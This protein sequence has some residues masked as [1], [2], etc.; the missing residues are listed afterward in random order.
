MILLGE[1]SS[2]MAL[3]VSVW[4]VVASAGAARLD[5]DDLAE[6]GRRALTATFALLLVAAAGLVT[7]LVTHDFTRTYVATHSG[8]NMPMVYAVAAFWSGLGG[9]MLLLAIALS[10]LTCVA[11]RTSGPSSRDARASGRVAFATL[12]IAMAIA[13]AC[14]AAK[15][16]A[17]SDF[18]V[19]EGQGLAPALQTMGFVFVPPL[20]ALALAAVVVLAASSWG[21]VIRSEIDRWARLAATLL[22]LALIARAYWTYTTLEGVR[23]WRW[24]VGEGALLGLW[25]L[26]EGLLHRASPNTGTVEMPATLLRLVFLGAVIGIVFGGPMSLH[27]ATTLDVIPRVLLAAGLLATAVVAWTRSPRSLRHVSSGANLG[28]DAGARHV[29][30][31]AIG[32][33]TACVLAALIAT[34]TIVPFVEAWM[35]GAA[36]M[37]TV[38]SDTVMVIASPLF[39]GAF[40]AAP[41]ASGAVSERRR[42]GVLSKALLVAGVVTLALVLSGLTSSFALVVSALGALALALIARD[43]VVT[44]R[45][46]ARALVHAGIVCVVVGLSLV[47]LTTTRDAT[48]KPGESV[49]MRDPMG[50]AWKFTGQGVSLYDVVN[51]RVVAVTVEATREGVARGIVKT[52]KRQIVDARGDT[53]G[54]PATGVG[55][56]HTA[57][58]DTRLELLDVNGEVARLRV[59]FVPFT[60]IVWFGAL[61]TLVGS[62]AQL[63]GRGNRQ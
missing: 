40:A 41:F 4:S 7:A 52:E 8:S 11:L 57:A 10:G 33:L 9:W 43:A 19:I 6:S 60:S 25:F 55:L 2:W 28:A 26:V 59:G 15:P 29:A 13:V 39:L 5:R 17:Q 35:H 49:E 46:T 12:P 16:F 51:S 22:I 61:L 34:L 3:V 20:D 27:S 63:L 53:L 45:A 58:L 42:L 21:A 56:L 30:P 47:S 48:L 32:V 31:E 1:L 54:P 24:G 23:F 18:A 38:T 37:S 14:F 50:H 44:E 62:L 36:T